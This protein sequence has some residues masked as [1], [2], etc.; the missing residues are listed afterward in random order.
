MYDKVVKNKKLQKELNMTVRQR[1]LSLKLLEQQ[2]RNP[3]FA[4]KIGVQVNVKEKENLEKQ[5]EKY[6][7]RGNE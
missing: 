3:E 6:G 2:R 5:K 7:Y 1:I 4:K